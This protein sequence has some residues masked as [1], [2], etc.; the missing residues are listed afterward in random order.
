ME[1]L[2]EKQHMTGI[3]T[4]M[5]NRKGYPVALKTPGPNK[6]S[7]IYYQID[8]PL[9][10]V[11]YST[12]TKSSGAVSIVVLT[13]RTPL[14]GV[15]IDEQKKPALFKLYDFT[16]TGMSYEKMGN[17]WLLLLSICVIVN[18]CNFAVNLCDHFVLLSICATRMLCYQSVRLRCFAVNLCDYVALLS[19]CSTI[20]PVCQSV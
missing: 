19:I 14:Q 20:L 6:S 7:E 12:V 3:G 2:W 4:W 8:G 15:T 5:S 18:F 16:K 11:R 1:W 13:T 17:E 10:M 9:A